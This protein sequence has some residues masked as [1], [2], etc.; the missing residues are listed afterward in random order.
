MPGYGGLEWCAVEPAQLVQQPV[1]LS[2]NISWVKGS[3][4]IRAGGDIVYHRESF[5]EIIIPN[6]LYVFDGSFTGHSMADMLLGIPNT[7]LL[8]PELF[9]PQVQGN[10]FHCRGCR[11][12][13]A[14]RPSSR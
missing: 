7:F 11:T 8:S 4:L 5:P 6:G 1:R 13:G 12:I 9:D 2:A 3:H 10:R 14:S